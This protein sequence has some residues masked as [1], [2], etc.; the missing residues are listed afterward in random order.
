MKNI[1]YIRTNVAKQVF[2]IMCFIW[3]ALRFIIMMEIIIFKVDGYY[4]ATNIPLTL[5]MYVVLF[6]IVIFFFRGY[7]YFGVK[8]NDEIVV[9]QD[10]LRR[11]EHAIAFKEVH[12]V[13]F[14]KK[15]IKFYFA[16]HPAPDAVPDLFIP[17]HR[18]GKVDAVEVNELFKKVRTFSHINIVKDFTVLPGYGKGNKALSYLYIAL[19]VMVF[20]TTA[21]PIKVIVVL[22]QYHH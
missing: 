15:G 17:F 2:L 14:D 5:I 7:K 9:Y 3:V 4:Q 6:A 10:R 20:M 13:I 11:K 1:R 8:F 12:R 22:W 18:L 19:T 16:A 21:T